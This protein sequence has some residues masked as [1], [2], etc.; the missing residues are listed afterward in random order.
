MEYLSEHHCEK[1][2]ES[3]P[4]VLDFHHHHSKDLTV[5][6]MVAGAYSLERIKREV[7]KCSVLCANCH[8]RHHAKEGNHWKHRIGGGNNGR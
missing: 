6:K 4:V 3:D 7:A 2:G 8:R 1:C 5:S